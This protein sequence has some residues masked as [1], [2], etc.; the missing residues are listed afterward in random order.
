VYASILVPLDGS[1]L[2]ERA[3]RYALPL[4]EQHGARLILLGVLEPVFPL[5]IGGGVPVRDP[6]LDRELQEERRK[7]VERVAK[8]LRRGTSVTVE[9]VLREG[10]VVP[11]IAHY[12][13]EANVQLIVMCTHGRGGFERLWLGSVADG[14]LRQLPVPILLVRAKRT[15]AKGEL[16]SPPFPRIVVALDG[17]PRSEGALDA[18]LALL[19]QAP[20]TM[21]LVNVVHPTA[22]LASSSFPSRVEAEMCADYL[23][24]LAARHRSEQCEIGVETTAHANVARAI[25]NLATRRDASL[26]A[27]ATQG[28]G[29]VERLIIG[30]VADKLIRTAP[31]PVLVVPSVAGPA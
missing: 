10:K 23:E 3:L 17:S 11:T 24:P 15:P 5:M 18:T 26:I 19:G 2:G 12:A 21:T 30:S 6:S 4:A 22:V 27:I 29:G 9:S 20:V 1:P 13:R 7:Y 31:M 16:E 28:L 14:L 25:T 8:R